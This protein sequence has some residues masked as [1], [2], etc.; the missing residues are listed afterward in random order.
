MT[1]QSHRKLADW[2]LGRLCNSLPAGW[3]AVVPSHCIVS[4]LGERLGPL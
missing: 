3:F 4:T 2:P 1:D